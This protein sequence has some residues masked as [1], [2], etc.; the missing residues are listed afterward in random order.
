[1]NQQTVQSSRSEKNTDF[2]QKKQPFN[3]KPLRSIIC[4]KEVIDGTLQIEIRS[5]DEHIIM[6]LQKK[7]CNP[8]SELG[9]I[10]FDIYNYYENGNCQTVDSKSM[11][12]FWESESCQYSLEFILNQNQVI[13]LKICHCPDIFAGI[14]TESELKLNIQIKLKTLMENFLEG[15]KKLLLHYGFI[16][17]KKRWQKHDFPIAIFLKLYNLLYGKPEGS[18]SLPCYLEC[19]Q[20]MLFG[21]FRYQNNL[22]SDLFKLF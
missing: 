22:K 7:F 8:L 2:F 4:L 13:N 3:T 20:K 9:E 19:L 15:M 5:S 17:Y 14:H 11:Y 10:L 18:N 12:L 16:G 21:K 6:N 1:M